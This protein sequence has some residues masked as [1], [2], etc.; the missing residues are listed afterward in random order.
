MPDKRPRD[1]Q[2]GGREASGVGCRT[3]P[4]L[5]PHARRDMIGLVDPRSASNGAPTRRTL[6]NRI[7]AASYPLLVRL[8]T[9]PRW[10]VGAVV[11]VLVVAGLLAPSPYGPICLAVVIALMAWVIFLAWHHG[12][13]TRKAIRLVALVLAVL[14]LALRLAS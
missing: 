8:H 13:A 3:P 10:L 1:A 9:M 11:V 14:A 2:S 4:R 5:D 12:D 7:E 6:R